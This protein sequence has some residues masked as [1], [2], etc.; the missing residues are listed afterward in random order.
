[1]YSI[2]FGDLVAALVKEDLSFSPSKVHKLIKEVLCGGYSS[3]SSKVVQYIEFIDPSTIYWNGFDCVQK[4][5]DD[6]SSA[7]DGPKRYS[8]LMVQFQS[9]ILILNLRQDHVSIVNTTNI[10]SP[11]SLYTP[12]IADI[13][14]ESL[15]AAGAGVAPISSNAVVV[16]E[17]LLVI[18]C[19]DGTLKLY[20]W[21]LK[22]VLKITHILS[23]WNNIGSTP[24]PKND[25]VVDI[26]VTNPHKLHPSEESARKPSI[27]CLTKKG[28]AAYLCPL[29]VQQ[30]NSTANTFGTKYDSSSSSMVVLDIGLPISRM[31][32]GFVPASMSKHD[33]EHSSM[34]HIFVKYDAFRDL[35]MWMAPSKSKT[36]LFVWDLSTLLG[37]RATKKQDSD[38]PEPILTVQFPYEN[39]SHMILPGWFHE[40]TPKD[41][42]A[43]VAVTKE[44]DMQILVAPLHNSGSTTKHPFQAIP[45]LSVNLTRLLQS[46]LELP[47]ER[48]FNYKVQSI[49]CP[50]LHDSSTF[51]VATTIGLLVIKMMDGN[52]V[53]FPGT[54]NAHF[55]ANL[56]TLGRAVL[57]VKGPQISYSPLEP[58]GGVLEVNPI[59]RLEYGNPSKATMVYE[60]PPPMHLPPEIHK[61]PVRLPPLFLPSPSRNYICCF[62]KEE[63]RYEVLSVSSIL[64][65][66]TN[67]SFPLATGNSLVV[68]SG[69]GVA[70]FA[71]IGDN[72]I[73]SL[74]YDPEQDLALK[75]GV[76]L[77]APEAAKL[78]ELKKLKDLARLKTYKQGVKSMVGTAGKLKSLEGLRDLGKD[79]GKF[80]LG[81]MKGVT[82]L[83]L[84]TVKL[85]TQATTKVR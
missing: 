70:S 62:W 68:A 83:S 14:A 69:N 81:A 55:S 71:W 31:E 67:K 11:S 51:V 35:L 54:R 39:M 75:V 73:F 8:Y 37:P 72:D 7:K 30:P 48:E 20:D 84:G 32:G 3:V 13:T 29:I 12:I 22:R 4:E 44:G 28:T 24:M 76:N 18:A 6:E 16:G 41:C 50:T 21:K 26:V 15:T 61:R 2:N 78:K 53:A 60:S 85:T 66:V 52:V 36:R 43:C 42:M 56:G 65:R 1:L 57:Y 5:N 40:S 49:S 38:R 45:L 46:D 23:M 80:G 77:S 79:T 33:E 34:E 63:M 74:L 82:K 10:K 58:V 59:G 27:V 47:E 25:Y 64:D 9:R 17:S 19:N